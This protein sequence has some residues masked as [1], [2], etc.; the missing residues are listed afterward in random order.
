MYAFVADGI[1][2]NSN[3]SLNI[4]RNE[5]PQVS[6]PALPSEE[7][8]NEQ[9]I[10]SVSFTPQPFIDYTQN[11]ESSVVF[12]GEKCVQEWLVSPASEQEITERTSEQAIK[13]RSERNGK[14]ATCDWTQLTDAPVDAATWAGYRQALR[15]ITSQEGFPWQIDWPIAPAS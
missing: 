9:G 11:A 12:D 6:L 1:V 3:L 2:T 10:Y 13:V 14:L 8:L 4:W 15:D 5:H 7:Q